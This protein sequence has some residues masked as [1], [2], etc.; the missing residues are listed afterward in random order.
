MIAELRRIRAG[1]HGP[2]PLHERSRESVLAEDPGDDYAD[3]IIGT[4]HKAPRRRR[5]PSKLAA[6]EL[7][8]D[9]GDDDNGSA[10]AQRNNHEPPRTPD[11]HAA[12]TLINTTRSSS[13]AATTGPASSQPLAPLRPGRQQA[14]AEQEA[15]TIKLAWTGNHAVEGTGSG[16]K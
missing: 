9:E 14:R 3:G 5:T 4:S 1:A 11:K 10:D 16:P 6:A 7:P 12:N 8:D 2:A 15:I 13:P